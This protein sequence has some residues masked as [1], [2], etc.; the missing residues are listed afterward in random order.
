M[1]NIGILDPLGTNIN[2]LNNLPYS[3]SYK[4]LGKV[5]SSFPVYKAVNQHITDIKNN[6]IIIVTSK[7]GSGKTVLMPKYALHAFKYD[8]KIFITLPKIIITKAAA[9]FAAATL[10]VELGKGAVGYVYRGSPK[11]AR[12]DNNKLTYGT[13][14]TLI[15]ML[16]KD[17]KLSE[18]NVIIIDEIH[19]RSLNIDFL[20][21]L[22][23]ETLKIRP[24]FKVILMS[25]TMRHHRHN[26]LQKLFLRFQIQAH[27]HSR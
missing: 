21:L 13:D 10:D 9:E 25:A 18:F 14:G 26:H 22:I 1:D 24:L 8:A 4:E 6:Q 23:R 15:A 27:L 16:L 2:P 17:P 5:W 11:S 12:S 20:I 7:T 3:D 19:E